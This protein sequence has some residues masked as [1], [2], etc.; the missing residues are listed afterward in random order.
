MAPRPFYPPPPPGWVALC[1]V[2]V[3]SNCYASLLHVRL[4]PCHILF[5]K[6][7]AGLILAFDR[8]IGCAVQAVQILL[9]PYIFVHISM[10][11]ACR[12]FRLGKGFD[13]ELGG[14]LILKV[15]R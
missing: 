12:L 6:R 11:L 13:H 15:S 4:L 8:R 5:R 2:T 9:S 3:H 7:T 10:R 1:N 14:S